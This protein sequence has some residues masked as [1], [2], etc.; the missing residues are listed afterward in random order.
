MNRENLFK[1]FFYFLKT[2]SIFLRGIFVKHVSDH[3]KIPVIINNFNRVST[4]R[5]LI[6]FLESRG[7]FNIFIIDNASTYPPL[8]EYYK[9]TPYKVFMLDQNIGYK[10]LWRSG[11]YKMFKNNFFVYTDSDIVPVE[12][13]PDDFMLRF[14]EVLKK[15][16]LATKAGFGLK[17]DDLPEHFANRESVIE[18]E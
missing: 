2:G 3:K 13:C 4:L 7:Y 15:H 17:I 12:S 9:N 14:L 10:A 8:L 1:R 11:I 6:S 5:D 16:P 18:W